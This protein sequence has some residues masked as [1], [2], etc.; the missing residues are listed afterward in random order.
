[1]YTRMYTYIYLYTC[2]Y[3]RLSDCSQVH[4]LQLTNR[5]EALRGPPNNTNTNKQRQ[6]IPYV[7]GRKYTIPAR[8]LTESRHKH[9]HILCVSRMKKLQKRLTLEDDPLMYLQHAGTRKDV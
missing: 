5:K 1:M 7:E 6:P 3:V 9:A 8:T 4:T 2:T